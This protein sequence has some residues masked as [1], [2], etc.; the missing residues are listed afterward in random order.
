MK[1]SKLNDDLFSHIHVI[2]SPQCPCGFRRETSKHF[3]L[4]CPLYTNA[5]NVMI[6]DLQEIGFK[7]TVSNLLSGCNRYSDEVNSKAVDIVHCFLKE[8]ERF[9]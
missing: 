6:S 2:D 4:D 1:C 7:V 3:L 8:S 9:I 5:R